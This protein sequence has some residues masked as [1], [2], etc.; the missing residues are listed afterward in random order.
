MVDLHSQDPGVYHYFG[1]S[2]PL[3]QGR[4]QHICRSTGALGIEAAAPMF[5]Q[6]LLFSRRL[7]AVGRSGLRPIGPNWGRSVKDWENGLWLIYVD[8]GLM[9]LKQ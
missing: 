1:M 9:W 3:A 7:L 5:S 4:R 2:S 8:I 6:N